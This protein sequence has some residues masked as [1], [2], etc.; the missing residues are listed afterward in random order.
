MSTKISL[1]WIKKIIREE[2]EATLSSQKQRP[3]EKR[4]DYDPK[5]SK[6]IQSDMQR[7]HKM[8]TKSW[9]F[10]RKEHEEIVSN[11]TPTPESSK[12][13]KMFFELLK[14][15]AMHLA[16]RGTGD[17]DLKKFELKSSDYSKINK[18]LQA[19]IALFGIPTDHPKFK[20]IYAQQK[21]I[22]EGKRPPDSKILISEGF[23]SKFWNFI[24]SI[25]DWVFATLI[26]FGI[27]ETY[28]T[29]EQAVR[30]LGTIK[31]KYF[32]DTKKYGG[33]RKTNALAIAFVGNPIYGH[34]GLCLIMNSRT[35]VYADFGRYA[36]MSYVLSS[37]KATFRKLK[38]KYK[39]GDKEAMRSIGTTRYKKISLPRALKYNGG[40]L[41]DQSRADIM[42]ALAKSGLPGND[43]INGQWK[44]LG[45]R[46][47]W[48]K[49]IDVKKANKMILNFPARP[50]SWWN[51]GELSGLTRSDA[52]DEL[53]KDGNKKAKKNKELQEIPMDEKASCAT[54]VMD[55]LNGASKTGSSMGAEL[56]SQLLASPHSIITTLANE[57][58]ERLETWRGSGNRKGGKFFKKRETF[59]SSD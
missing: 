30:A 4:P 53:S 51:T 13:H 6:L 31:Q 26:D 52:E 1:K 57:F 17:D 16:A 36:T 22:S 3:L 21:A 48:I 12:E 43:N 9:F 24:V 7:L 8:A 32:R 5:L 59:T 45:S 42:N 55:I 41:T 25:W 54:F 10:G 40:D 18:G 27:S 28:R 20:E 39:L 38:R 47:A 29:I 35:L 15:V 34:S 56:R 49:D 23:W 50:Y 46:V 11:F 37:A 19:A 58:D 33:E 44:W 2:T 14:A